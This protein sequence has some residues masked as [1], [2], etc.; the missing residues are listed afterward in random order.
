MLLLLVAIPLL[1]T[2]C[3]ASSVSIS[4]EASFGRPPY[5]L[6][7][8]WVR[9]PYKR[10]GLTNGRETAAQENESCYFPLLNRIAEGTFAD[11]TEEKTYER[12]LET[13]RNDGHLDRDGISLFQYALSIHSAAPRIEAH[14]Q[15]Y[16]STVE[17]SLG[18]G[19]DAVCQIWVH[20]NEKQYCSPTLE[21]AQQDY[22]GPEKELP[23]DRVTGKG[24]ASILY[25]DIES[26]LFAHFHQT[27]SETA[28]AG[29]T[30]YRVRYRPMRQGGP[31]LV[32]GYGVEL[33]LKRTDYIVIDDRQTG[34]AESPTEDMPDL[35]PLSSSEITVLGVKTASYVYDSEDPLATLEEILQDFPKW[36]SKLAS[37]NVSQAF[38]EEWQ[39]NR[40]T[41]LNQGYNVIWMNGLQ[42]DARH[43][44]AYALLDKIRYE[45]D[46]IK[47]FK[48]FTSKEAISLISHTAIAQAKTN[49]EPPRYDWQGPVIWL[50]NIE[51][52]KRYQAWS[53]ESSGLNQMMYPGQLPAIKRDIHNVVF[54]ADFADPKD[55][56]II[57]TLQVFVQ[58]NYPVRLGF[59]ARISDANSAKQDVL[60]RY[61]MDY[62]GSKVAYEWLQASVKSKTGYSWATFDKFISGQE[63]VDEKESL[64]E[65]E[66][67]ELYEEKAAET[68]AYLE[69]LGLTGPSPPILVNGV[70][71]PRN[72]MWM[73]S[74]INRVS[75]DLQALQSRAYYEAIPDDEWLA[76]FFLQGAMT[77]RNGMIIPEDE[78]MVQTFPIKD[79]DLPRVSEDAD[80]MKQFLTHWVFVLDLDSESGRD[81]LHE[82]MEFKK[83]QPEAEIRILH[84]SAGNLNL[85]SSRFMPGSLT[86][87]EVQQILQEPKAE[88]DELAET[89]WQRFED[90]VS[91]WGLKPG[92]NAILLNGRLIGPLKS[93]SAE[94]LLSLMNYERK[95]RIAPVAT[96][97]AGLGLEDKITSALK[98]AEITSLVTRSGRSEIPEGIFDTSST[99]RMNAFEAWDGGIKKGD[100]D[101][102]IQIVASIDPASEIAQRWVPILRVLS[103]LDGVHLRVYL[104]PRDTL[105]DLP[106][107][108][109]YRHVLHSKPGNANAAFDVP[110]QV[111]LNLALD[112]PPAWLVAAKETTYDLDNLKLEK[113]ETVEAVYALE[114]ILIEGHSRDVNNGQP[115]R[116]VQL[117]LGND[118]TLIMANVGYF[119]FKANPG[120][121]SIALKGGRSAEIFNIDGL[122][123]DGYYSND[124]D[125]EIAL[126]SFQGKTLFPRLSRLPGHEEDDVLEEKKAGWNLW[127]SKSKQ[128]ADINIFSVA[129]GHLYERMLNIMMVSVMKN[130]KHTVKFWFISQ[131][132]SPSF[133]ETVPALAAHYG[134]DYEM[135]TYKWPHWLR[136]QKEKQ[137]EIWGYKILFLDVLFPLSL[138]KVIF[139]D[140]D[141]IVRTDMYDLV[142]HDLKGAPYGFTPMCD[143]RTEMEG[144]RFWKQGYWKNALRGRPYH[145]SALYVVDL[146]LFRQM[147]AGDRLRGQYHQ[148]SADPNSLSN[149]D[150]DLPNNMQMTLPIHSL[151]Q[152]WLWCETWCSDESLKDAKTI[153]LC[154][155]P[156]T[157]EPKLTRARRQVPE[158]TK[159]DD[160]IANVIQRRQGGGVQEELDNS[161]GKAVT[162]STD[163]VKIATSTAPIATPSDQGKQQEQIKD[164]L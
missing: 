28:M 36:A 145:I 135:V 62:Y 111:L 83:T 37:N 54:A 44:N 128:H 27:L 126:M 101:S 23:F 34:G 51:Q 114:H 96:A 124:T 49:N 156:E 95:K 68:K 91:A 149:L 117:V 61:L 130:T 13:L 57:E 67:F 17:K 22:D 42:V 81:I 147:A 139:V 150:Q 70:A 20:F 140:A 148:L 8:L 104:N 105:Q 164:E 69:R 14:Y 123:T 134:F 85:H 89:F 97:L 125:T 12:F 79:L 24:P 143:S 39:S 35:K 2:V 87:E 136:G 102:N 151:P 78:D 154:N 33:A 40:N 129:S 127:P 46:L 86:P 74:M 18:K 5:L 19:Q 112:V 158:W 66:I 43:V 94:D 80:S 1:A 98:H 119:Q 7:L 58:R 144:Y 159:Y 155:N 41:Y 146:K 65:K 108:R 50:N 160:E 53:A 52:D 31:L 47:G 141:Q 82:A 115:P 38:V 60:V 48:G 116:G 132:L 163:E 15:F 138:D 64:T 153:D 77:K 9:Q 4:L 93:F 32:S 90:T 100:P 6:E 162:E 30:S 121:Y 55:L 142:T 59:V 29:Q 84:N 10:N 131:F 75:I 25:A 157:K 152:E 110:R 113:G 71:I 63:V 16:N 73:Q 106:I 3:Y 133:K 92:E 109:F 137:R 26:P 21:R 161:G 99:I 88:V 103:E 72:D 56:D 122:G 107:K 45:R 11:L 76:G 120:F 118:D